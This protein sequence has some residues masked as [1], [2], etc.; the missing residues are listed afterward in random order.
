MRTFSF[1]GIRA[2]QFSIY[3]SSDTFLNSPAYAYEEYEVP[4]RNG[5]LLKYDKHLQNVV[6]QFNCFCKDNVTV[7]LDAFKQALYA[8]SGYMRIES[9]YEP[10]TYQMGY[11]AEG[12]EFEPFDASGDFSAQFTITFSCKPQKWFKNVTTETVTV[13]EAGIYKV[14]KRT[15]TFI[16][17]MFNALPISAIPEGDTFYL[18]SVYKKPATSLQI[19]AS[20]STG[21]FLALC[22]E[23]MSDAFDGVKLYSSNGDIPLQDATIRSSVQ[24]RW[25]TNQPSGILNEFYS[26]TAD[27]YTDVSNTKTINAGTPVTVTNSDALGASVSAVAFPVMPVLVTNPKPLFLNASGTLDGVQTWEMFVRVGFD[28]MS[29]SELT[30]I[31][32][33]WLD[34][35]YHGC[36]LVIDLTNLSV[37]LSKDGEKY[38]L[39]E[40][41]EIDGAVGMCDSVTIHTVGYSGTTATL[42]LTANVEWWKV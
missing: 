25:V 13:H 30:D 4:S 22:G 33:Y 42:R 35:N 2:D 6:R 34:S 29:T 37:Y 10:D 26:L 41:T 17:K 14:L 15:D 16:Q 38:I 9:D 23:K 39:D 27:G 19:S 28:L 1:N 11:L 20:M 8:N 5:A 40:Y 31:D 24:F 7:N 36:D 21:G 18:I 12:I 3:V 32:N